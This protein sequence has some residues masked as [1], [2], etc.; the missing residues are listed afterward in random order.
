MKNTD[1]TNNIFEFLRL[2]RCITVQSHKI[3]LRSLGQLQRGQNSLCKVPPPPLAA[4]LSRNHEKSTTASQLLHHHLHPRPGCS[5]RK[6]VQNGGRD[7]ANRT[8]SQC[9]PRSPPA[10]KRY[11]ASSSLAVPASA[12]PA[13]KQTLPAES[14]L[15]QEASKPQYSLAL[16]TIVSNESVPPNTRL[17]AALAFKNFIRTNYVVRPL[18]AS[19]SAPRKQRR[20]DAPS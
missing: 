9:Y 11:T 7:G 3:L 10:Q 18:S 5:L 13:N 8:A 2:C 14:A 20:H 1:A 19:R 4:A 16:L 17:A 12:L 6:V 15:K